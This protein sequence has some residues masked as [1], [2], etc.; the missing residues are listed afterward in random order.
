LKQITSTYVLAQTILSPPANPSLHQNI[1][2]LDYQGLL[3]LRDQASVDQLSEERNE[4]KNQDFT[5]IFTSCIYIFYHHHHRHYGILASLCFCPGDKV[6][7]K[8]LKSNFGIKLRINP[9]LRPLVR[10]PP[11]RNTLYF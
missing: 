5:A 3:F 7:N 10:F 2:I 1:C 4:E 9:S 6:S 11:D 8:I